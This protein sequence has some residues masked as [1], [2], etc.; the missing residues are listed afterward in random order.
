VAVAG[1]A[2]RVWVTLRSYGSNDLIY[3]QQF[4]ETIRDLG[5]LECYR[6]IK[7]FNHPPLMGLW[8]MMVSDAS[9]VY[10]VRF[11]PL[12]KILPLCADAGTA[13]LLARIWR[14]RATLAVGLFALSPAAILLSA[15][16]GNTDSVA[17][18]LCLWA[19]FLFDRGAF[20]HAGL[21]LGGAINVKLIP[22]L[23]IAVFV[24]QAR[25]WRDLRRFAAGLAVGAVPFVPLLL[26]L[27][28]RFVANVLAYKS[29]PNHWGFIAL[30]EAGEVTP[31]LERA[32]AVLFE[33]FRAQGRLLV[34]AAPLAIGAW[35]RRRGSTATPLAAAAFILFLAFAPGFGVQYSIYALPLLLGSDLALGAI[36]SLVVGLF[37]LVSYV[38]MWTGTSPWFSDFNLRQPALAKL[39]GLVA[40]T[41]L[42]PIVH[43]LLR[44]KPAPP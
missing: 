14:E 12:F 29:I 3:W 27:R 21:A 16:H 17:A 39:L 22:V 36:Y 20:L 31:H 26:I 19:A 1:L 5:L 13:L 38:E 4:G 23:L 10:G 43:A 8:S 25:S 34:L 41:A 28:G 7:Y 30:L 40:W 24:F 42:F 32:S 44:R 37:L 2:L 9:H 6:T 15:Y 33:L 35:G 11:A 18:C